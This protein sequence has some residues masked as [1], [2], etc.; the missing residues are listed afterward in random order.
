MASR[1]MWLR[2]FLVVSVLFSLTLVAI[3]AIRGSDIDWYTVVATL[4]SSFLGGVISILIDRASQKKNA[5]ETLLLIEKRLSDYARALQGKD[6]MTSNDQRLSSITGRWNQ[7]N[8]TIRVG[9]RYWIHTEYDIQAS[10]LGEISFNVD[11]ADNKGGIA[12]YRY[13]GVLRDD[14]V[15]L[16]GK[17]TSG[18]QPCFVEIWPHL[19]NAAAQYHIGICFN[20]AWDLHETVIP[21]LLSRKPLTD[22]RKIDNGVLDQLWVSAV[23]KS[24]LDVFPRVIDLLGDGK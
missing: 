10:P 6:L 4:G 18:E 1:E 22:R 8:V 24:N 17:S 13:E 3:G 7:Y 5:D 11:Y 15:I 19:A 21:C 23:K 20:Q 16:I 2:A 12:T 14:R 9:E